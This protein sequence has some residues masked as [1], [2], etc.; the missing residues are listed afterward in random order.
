VAFPGQNCATLVCS[1][2]AFF[3]CTFCFTREYQKE[4]V[5]KG[6]D[7]IKLIILTASSRTFVSGDG[8]ALLLF[9][10]HA[11]AVWRTALAASTARCHCLDLCCGAR[12]FTYHAF[13]SSVQMS[14]CEKGT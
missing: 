2:I 11:C 7:L 5:L 3:L 4:S 14:P 13:A 6:D 12:S 8:S 1:K 10:Y 9:F